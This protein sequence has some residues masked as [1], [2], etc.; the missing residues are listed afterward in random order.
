MSLKILENNRLKN[1]V[2]IK[3]SKNSSTQGEANFINY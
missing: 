1:Y 3:E 2:K